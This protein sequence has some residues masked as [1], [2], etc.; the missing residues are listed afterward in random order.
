MGINSSSIFYGVKDVRIAPAS[1]YLDQYS[2]VLN[3]SNS[4]GFK[5]STQVVRTSEPIKRTLSKGGI[6]F[7]QTIGYKK[8]EISVVTSI[9][10]F[11]PSN[12]GIV[13]GRSSD[14]TTDQTLIPKDFP[15]FMSS[16]S[17]F[18]LEIV[19]LYVNKTN[20]TTFIIP[21]AELV[22]DADFPFS[23][24]TWLNSP[25]SFMSIPVFNSTWKAT[26]IGRMFIS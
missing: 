12:I 20:L 22:S 8:E 16:V 9:Q 7:D 13:L 1:A 17:E 25:I 2:S 3:S 14:I 24:D 21:K 10:E 4:I 6:A 11:T 19:S 26:P 23:D 5:G 18:R 15:L